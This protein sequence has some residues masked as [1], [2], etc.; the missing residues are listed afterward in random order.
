MADNLTAAKRAVYALLDPVV[1]ILL[2]SGI[3]FAQF[4]ALA[5]QVYVAVATRDFGLRGRPTNISRVALLTGLTRR[6]VRKQ[7]QLIEAQEPDTGGRVSNIARVLYYWHTDADYL[8]GTG[9]PRRL[10]ADGPAPSFETLYRSYGGGDVPC[11][12]ALKELLGSATVVLDD[13]GLLAAKRR[14]F[15]PAESDPVAIE[16]AGE[17]LTDIGDTV[18]YNLFRAPGEVGRFEGRAT[19][20]YMPE[21]LLEDY[22][23][24][25]EV[26]GQRFLELVDEWLSAHEDDSRGER[27][28]V[29]IGVYQIMA[30][31][32]EG[33]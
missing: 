2:R 23:N 21:A 22:R 11:T 31:R 3:P 18:T 33:D 20:R 12:A 27:R 4:S 26:E 28:R 16:R 7:R 8:D 1:R 32:D 15:M 13:D 14:Y 30:P 29:G 19:S 5:K 10:P 9:A 6:D 24:F 17:V 25:V